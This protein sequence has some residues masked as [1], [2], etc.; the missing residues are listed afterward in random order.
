MAFFNTQ[1][2]AAPRAEFDHTALIE[3]LAQRIVA[4][5]MAAPAVLLLESIRPLSRL[6]AQTLLVFSPVMALI[7][8]PSRYGEIVDLLQDPR[9][10]ASL[11]AA[12]EARETQR[13]SA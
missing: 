13:R 12:I 4:R 1:A 5:R 9:N 10:V 6:A 3:M 11:V 2:F 8:S 7:V